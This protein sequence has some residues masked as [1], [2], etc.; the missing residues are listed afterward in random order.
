MLWGL[1][2]QHT[3]GNLLQVKMSDKKCKDKTESS[4]EELPDNGR[5]K[6]GRIVSNRNVISSV[7][8]S[9]NPIDKEEAN[10]DGNN[11]W[12]LTDDYS[13][14]QEVPLDELDTAESKKEELSENTE[15]EDDET[16]KKDNDLKELKKK[17]VSRILVAI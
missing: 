15:E 7:K 9:D 2:P 14:V 17:E 3:R 8:K 11:D 5:R 16:E 10:P 1:T 12:K 13:G 6:A 4:H